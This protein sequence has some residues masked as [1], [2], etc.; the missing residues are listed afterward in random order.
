ML[1]AQSQGMQYKQEKNTP[2]ANQHSSESFSQ[3]RS[4]QQFNPESLLQSSDSCEVGDSS[5]I[6][7]RSDSAVG[8]SSQFSQLPS[9]NLL[10]PRGDNQSLGEESAVFSSRIAGEVGT[11]PIN[12]FSSNFSGAD[13][14]PLHHASTVNHVDVHPPVPHHLVG[15]PADN[16]QRFRKEACQNHPVRYYSGLYIDQSG[17]SEGAG[18]MATTKPETGILLKDAVEAVL[19]HWSETNALTEKSLQK[20]D[21]LLHRY[22]I[23]TANL[24]APALMDQSEAI[25]AQWIN[26]KGRDRS[27]NIIEPS[28]STQNL[29]RSA[30]RKFYR[31]AEILKLA[32]TGLMVR[33][34]VAPRPVGLARPLTDDEAHRVWM[35]ANDAGPCTRRPVMFALLFSGIH[36]SEVGLI[37]VRDVDTNNR[38]I[39]AHGDTQRLQSRWIDIQEP[40]WTAILQRI[41]YVREWMPAHQSIENFQ[42]TQGASKKPMGYSHNRAASACK[43]VFRMVGLHKEADITPTSVS[44]YC[45]GRML[46]EG[47]RIETIAQTLG[48]A[49]LDSCAKALGYN[50][51]TGEIA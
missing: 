13:G 11:E 32:D 21:D 25:A 33:T 16:P 15:A 19:K 9:S 27:R 3:S 50:W 20:F 4:R 30:L 29:R 8:D 36:S 6:N 35:V 41:Q 28:T 42:L 22:C 24:G 31:D 14:L 40:L 12:V 1:H 43:E 49:S 34:H 5:T 38:R 10:P 37:T 39:W 17:L 48:Y 51:V 18:K 7:D 26:A 2:A 45:G 23:F 47:E 46:R 44:L